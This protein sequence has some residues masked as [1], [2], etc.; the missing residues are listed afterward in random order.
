MK[1]E[2]HNAKI[3]PLLGL[4]DDIKKFENHFS[5]NTEILAP[6][7]I[8]IKKPLRSKS[9]VNWSHCFLINL[10]LQLIYSMFPKQKQHRP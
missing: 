10:S 8:E 3:G 1:F 7:G 2:F 4:T 9:M 6:Y 5:V